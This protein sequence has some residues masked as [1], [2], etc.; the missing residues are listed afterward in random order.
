MASTA[1]EEAGSVAK[2]AEQ[3]GSGP[4]ARSIHESAKK[5]RIQSDI[6]ASTFANVS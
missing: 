3:S 5:L 6:A 2:N 4:A 1:A